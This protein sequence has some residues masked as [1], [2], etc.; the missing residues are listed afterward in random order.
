MTHFSGKWIHSH[1]VYQYELY[2][3]HL[4]HTLNRHSYTMQVKAE[5]MGRTDI[6]IRIAM[7]FELISF[8]FLSFSKLF[9]F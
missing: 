4:V 2:S 1:I 9:T 8:Y 7:I 6:E 5:Q 3:W